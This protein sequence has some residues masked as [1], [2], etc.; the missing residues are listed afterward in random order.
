MVRFIVCFCLFLFPQLC[1]RLLSH[2]PI[3]GIRRNS[4][5]GIPIIRGRSSKLPGRNEEP[6]CPKERVTDPRNLPFMKTDGGIAPAEEFS[7][8]R[9]RGPQ[10]REEFSDNNNRRVCSYRRSCKEIEECDPGDTSV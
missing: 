8:F 10:R 6:G 5:G 1:S 4:G 9:K 2:R 3:S 7:L